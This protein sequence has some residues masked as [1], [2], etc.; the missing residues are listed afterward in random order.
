MTARVVANI[1]HVFVVAPV[2]ACKHALIYIGHGASEC[3]VC[4]IINRSA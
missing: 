2:I 1:S 4:E 3:R